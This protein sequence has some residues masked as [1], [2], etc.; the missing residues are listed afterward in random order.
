M[1]K[2]TARRWPSI[3]PTHLELKGTQDLFEYTL[4]MTPVI[5]AVAVAQLPALA[6]SFLLHRIASYQTSQFCS[7]ICL[8]RCLVGF[9]ACAILQDGFPG[10]AVFCLK[11]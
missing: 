7:L 6:E 5:F 10:K 2:H 4:I 1:A 9:R 3:A 8:V 11:P